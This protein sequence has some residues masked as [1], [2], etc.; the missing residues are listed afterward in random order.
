MTGS[1]R[2]VKWTG[3]GKCCEGQ[4]LGER[5]WWLGL[6]QQQV[7]YPPRVN[8][9]TRECQEAQVGCGEV[10]GGGYPL[11]EVPGQDGSARGQQESD[12]WSSQN[13]MRVHCQWIAQGAA[14]RRQMPVQSGL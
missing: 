5:G 14:Q 3:E 11:G 4:P 1:G 10:L 2:C 6:G 9:H 7:C 13:G 12:F 8:E